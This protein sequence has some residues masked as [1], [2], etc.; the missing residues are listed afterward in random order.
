MTT[1]SEQDALHK[2]SQLPPYLFASSSAGD[3]PGGGA[4][5]PKGELKV[6]TLKISSKNRC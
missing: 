5:A 6:D 3:G 4:G 1:Y 2:T